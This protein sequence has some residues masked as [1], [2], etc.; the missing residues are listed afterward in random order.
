MRDV[1]AAAAD[2]PPEPSSITRRAEGERGVPNFIPDL[3][4]NLLAVASKSVWND[5]LPG[6]RRQARRAEPGVARAVPS[7][8]ARVF[9][10]IDRGGEQ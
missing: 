10:R 8:M 6:G 2:R 7:F 5:L 9:P 4:A 3:I 1:V